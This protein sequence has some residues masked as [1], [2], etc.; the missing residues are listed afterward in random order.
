MHRDRAM[1]SGD[2]LVPFCRNVMGR[3]PD[4]LRQVLWA[5]ASIRRGAVRANARAPVF[6]FVL[7]A[8]LLVLAVP[9]ANAQDIPPTAPCAPGWNRTPPGWYTVRFTPDCSNIYTFAGSGY[10]WNPSPIPVPPT[11]DDTFT[12]MIFIENTFDPSANW[13]EEIGTTI[14]KLVPGRTYKIPFLVLPWAGR[15][16]NHI[17]EPCKGLIATVGGQ[18]QTFATPY[19]GQWALK[20][21]VFT[22][23][24]SE[25]TL[26]IQPQDRSGKCVVNFALG[27]API[28]V[29]KTA[30]LGGSSAGDTVTFTMTIENTGIETLTN[31]RIAEDYLER[32][33]GTKLNLTSGPTFV[34]N[35]GAS[36]AGTLVP[37]E[38]ATFT[39][40][41]R[42]AQADI[43]DGRLT[44]QA[45]GVGTSPTLGEVRAYSRASA[46]AD[47][48]GTE[49]IIPRM[50]AISLDK[51]GTIVDA[52]GNGITDAG[53]EID[54][55]FPVT[56]TGNVML[57][58]VT[59]SDATPGVTVSGSAIASLSPGST[60]RTAYSARYTLTQ[61]DLDN[62]R[63]SNTASATA[64]TSTNVS[65]H[66]RAGLTTTLPSTLRLSLDKVGRISDDNGNGALDAGETLIYTFAVTNTGNVTLSNVTV[67]D[68][69][70]SVSG[71]PIA[72]LAPAQTDGTAYT[73]SYVVTQA[74]VDRGVYVNTATAAGT[75]PNGTSASTTDS[76]TVPADAAGKL[77][78]VKRGT[79]VDAN[80][81]GVTDAG[82][83]VA[84]AFRVTNEGN[85]T[86]SNIVLTD[87]DVVV[88][89]GPIAS[90]APRASDNRTFTA[91]RDITQAQMDAGAIENT[92]T[93]RGVTP[94]G[95]PVTAEGSTVNVLAAVERISLEKAATYVDAN[96]NGVAD[97]GDHIAFA[98][99]VTNDGNVTLSDISLEDPGVTLSG[100]PISGL[101]PGGVD[102]VTFSARYPLS[103][104]DVDAGRVS[105]TARV[106][107]LSPE[108]R[109]VTDTSDAHVI[110]ARHPELDLSKSGELRETGGDGFLDAG[111]QIVY[112]FVATNSGNVT[113]TD[114]RPQDRGPL[115]AG[116]AG[117]GRLSDF[118][119]ARADLGPGAS[120][121]FTAVY[122]MSAEDATDAQ[123]PGNLV[124]NTA[125]AL[126][127]DPGGL[128]VASPEAH[129][130]LDL[131]GTAEFTIGKAAAF[132]QVVRGQ[133]VPYTIRVVM[134]G[135]RSTATADIIDEIPARFFY[136]E[137]SA[138][139]K[140]VP[141]E[142]QIDGRRLIFRHVA[143]QPDEE[144]VITLNL[145]VSGAAT[146]GEYV[147]RAWVERP[148]GE[149][150]SSIATARVE[151]ASEPVFDCGGI[152][153]KVFDDAN[154]NGYQ[155]HGERGL[156]GARVATVNGLLVTSD[157]NGRFHVA[158][159]VLPDGRF[160]ANYI[161][162]LDPRSLPTGYRITTAN[163]R[164]VRLTAG[165]V[166]KVSF[167]AA[168]GRVVGF[169]LFDAAFEAGSATL[170]AEWQARL[171]QVIALLDRQPSVLRLA[172]RGT[173][174][175][176]KLAAQRIR[177]VRRLVAE[178]WRSRG[179]RYHLEI[180]ARIDAG[181]GAPNDRG[182]PPSRP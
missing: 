73:A 45:V 80:G 126:G 30:A 110:L 66:D 163:P 38:I 107:A 144:V 35:S 156:P 182:A 76:A 85:V 177:E 56:N 175:D 132:A 43:D 170:K 180:E 158:C 69:G 70:V 23:S 28:S 41:Y 94:A 18:P 12:D 171:W 26:T 53:D 24:R 9:A 115:V 86:L 102:D 16:A 146:A 75:A 8:V 91:R 65:V 168:L 83:Q 157:R 47:E 36:P 48:G 13:I 160:G 104:A 162:K 153:G 33:D 99:R 174:G 137:G 130:Q 100:G 15:E 31:V 131:A 109:S 2:R 117:T 68:P 42:L 178:E 39:A 147:N 118:T 112:T 14:T 77:R 106:L 101:A 81:N 3:L 46:D 169:D 97:V 7:S 89:G 17:Y 120:Q 136:V 40:T 20:A 32:S 133:Q 164:V 123:V 34:S 108:G 152:L 116:R 98:F 61:A 93:V 21:L 71:S 11:G 4:K 5:A 6:M 72:S 52:N 67:D 129:A 44:N 165:K 173:A 58:N 105:N 88:S 96:G 122:T 166:S 140:G 119:P 78:L 25:E 159:A 124:H 54:Y 37:D 55:S 143:V 145:T 179:G 60:N 167:G 95:D 49:V 111:D 181:A 128:Q 92:A 62:G 29:I 79:I 82:D 63:V 176:A 51:R 27:V 74:D 148:P 127:T 135:L 87:P 134:T 125:R 155:D 114:V 19:T 161:V 84:Y 59:V 142:P 90:L 149:T 151:V 22:A 1:R 64:V 50:P 139:V 172:Y 10:P 150:A 57:A 121:T 141:T 154:R 113:L 138:T 103:Q